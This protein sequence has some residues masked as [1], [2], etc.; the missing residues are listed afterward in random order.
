MVNHL[1]SI[2]GRYVV[3]GQHNKE[4]ASNPGQY[5]QQVKDITGQYPGLWGGDLMFRP[6]DVANR[7]RVV[8]QAKVEWA[9]GSLVTLTWHVCTPTGGSTCQ[10]DGGVKTQISQAQFTEVVTNGTALNNAWKRRLDEVVP[11]L[12]QL[13]AA[14]VPVLFRPL[15]EMNEA[16]NWWGN[17]PG[18]EGSA[19]LYRITRDHLTAKGL[20][21]L[22]W[23]W[24][25]QDNPAGGW[26]S[27][28]PGA[29]YVDV[30]SLDVWY[31]GLPSSGDYQQIQDIA[32]G[33]PIALAETGKVPGNAML[34][35]QTRWSYFMVWSEHLR[36]NNT[37]AEVQ[38]GY[39]HPRTLNQGE[40]TVPRNGS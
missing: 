3:S 39:F 14:G 32:A 17:R 12:Q 23:V 2:T 31:K 9:N 10:F 40:F 1:G 11:Y 30:V 34:T 16:W 29:Q 4:P 28:Y 24:N 36:G 8:D 22:V 38:A 18:P 27:Y 20:D 21:N 5:T 15:H 33:K 35:S 6:E 37:P 25:V 19:K 7:Q 13:K 26:A